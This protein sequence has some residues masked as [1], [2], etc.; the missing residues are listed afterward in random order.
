VES[1]PADL[2]ALLTVSGTTHTNANDYPADAWSFAGNGNYNSANGIVH[3]VIDKAD[4]I[5]TVNGY[6]GV[7]DGNAHGASGTATGVGSVDLSS[8]LN[9]GSSFTNVPGGTA[10]WTFSNPNYNDQSGDASITISKA[11]PTIVV[12]PYHVTW[13]GGAHTAT[14]SAKGVKAEVLSGLDLSLTTHTHSGNYTDSWT[15]TDNTG[16]YNNAG[17]SVNDIIDPNPIVINTTVGSIACNGGTT[18]LTIHATGGD[19]IPYKFSLNGGTCQS[20]SNF[21]V[22]AGTYSVTVKDA[23]GLPYT[24]SNIGVN[25]P[26]VLTAYVTNGAVTN[27]DGSPKNISDTTINR[28]LYFGYS[29]DQTVIFKVAPTGGTAPYKVKI[30]IDRNLQ[31]NVINSTGTEIWNS[32]ISG[33]GSK[34]DSNAVCGN[35]KPTNYTATIDSQMLANSWVQVQATLLDTALFSICITDANGCSYT[36]KDSIFAEDDRCFAGNSKITK[37]QLCHRTGDPKNPC[38]TICV[39]SSAVNEHLLHGDS[40]GA[41]PKNGCGT[42]YNNS[43]PVSAQTLGDDKLQVKIMPNPSDRGI[44]FN[45]IAKGRNNEE[46]QITVL[47][48]LGQVVYSTKGATNQTYR[49]G[50]DFMSGMYFVEVL[51]GKN[52]QILKV[53]KQ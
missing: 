32:S 49:F 48:M 22:P 28:H 12:T 15:F 18:T 8:S 30:S 46:V 4:A 33:A 37:V 27:A 16:N 29:G 38:V 47:N 2:S 20:D 41:C 31:C 25:Q 40:F 1:T 26:T 43:S 51:Q 14:G 44:P 6:T 36:R 21:I 39:D 19:G 35:I 53:I 42:S 9:L 7:Y 23:E 17:S 52:I 13:D 11:N 24:K 5:V 45:L 3:D 34:R 10:H 50:S